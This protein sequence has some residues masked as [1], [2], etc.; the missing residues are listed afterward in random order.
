MLTETDTPGAGIALV[1]EDTFL[2][3]LRDDNPNIANPNVWGFVGGGIEE[4]ET[5][6]EAIRRELREEIGIVPRHLTCI[7]HTT[8]NKFRFIAYLDDEEAEKLVLGEGQEIR[9]FRPEEVSDMALSPR[10]KI[11]FETYRSGVEKLIRRERVSAE[12]FGLE[13]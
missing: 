10:V 6:E 2:L 1:Y 9:F 8:D 13:T 11:F 5:P 12:D 7:G 4:G 3:Q